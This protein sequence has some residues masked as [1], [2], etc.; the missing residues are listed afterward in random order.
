MAWP[1]E[2]Q[3]CAT[4]VLLLS[5]PLFATNRVSA[6]VTTAGPTRARNARS[7]ESTDGGM[8]VMTV[9][10]ISLSTAPDRIAPRFRGHR[11]DETGLS[12]VDASLASPS[13]G[14]QSTGWPP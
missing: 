8:R 14:D 11:V 9:I 5:T 1:I 4:Q 7:I 6:S 10:L 13:W 2:R 3:G 12:A